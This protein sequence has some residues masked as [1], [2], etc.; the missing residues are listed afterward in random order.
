MSDQQSEQVRLLI[1]SNKELYAA[2]EFGM[3]VKAFLGSKLGKYLVERAEAQRD[4]AITELVNCRASDYDR[5]REL[6]NTVQR[7]ESIQYWMAEI[8]TE[9]HAAQETLLAQDRASTDEADQ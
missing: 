1:E 4:E 6:Q 8:I 5:I 2:V 3:E 7:A 9:A